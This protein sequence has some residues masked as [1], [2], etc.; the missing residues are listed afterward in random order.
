MAKPVHIHN[1]K[2]TP[3][4]IQ[5]SK[6]AGDQAE[7]SSDDATYTV[8]FG[9]DSPFVRSSFTVRPVPGGSASS[10]PLK[11]NVVLKKYNYT[12]TPAGAAVGADP[13]VDVV[14]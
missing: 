8:D 2:A 13:D 3:D 6:S 14:P 1:K 12:V 5:L 10:G 9:A 4:P 11:N 7:W